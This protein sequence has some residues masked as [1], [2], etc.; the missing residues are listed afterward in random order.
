MYVNFTLVLIHKILPCLLLFCFFFLKRRGS[1]KHPCI[2]FIT[3]WYC[4][5]RSR[6]ALV[7]TPPYFAE[8]VLTVCGFPSVASFHF[9]ECLF[10]LYKISRSGSTPLCFMVEK[11]GNHT[12]GA[13]FC[14]SRHTCW[15]RL[16][17]IH[18]IVDI[19]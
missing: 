12:F 9:E 1:H 2:V 13:S 6:G 18:T 17:I 19:L 7:C 15:W 4:I 8:T 14:W 5:Y 3:K 11:F 16:V 10:P